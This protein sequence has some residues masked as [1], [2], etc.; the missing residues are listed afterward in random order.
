MEKKLEKCGLMTAETKIIIG[1]CFIVPNHLA[2]AKEL[3]PFELLGKKDLAFKKMMAKEVHSK[4]QVP[5]DNVYVQVWCC[6]PGDRSKDSTWVDGYEMAPS[7]YW[8]LDLYND[9][10]DKDL[11]E[12]FPKYLPLCLLKDLKDGDKIYIST[13]WGLVE[14]TMNQSGGDGRYG[15]FGKFEEVLQMLQKNF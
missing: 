5:T 15:K 2:D 10:K 14:L 11:G 8:D 7:K 13:K 1:E 4:I 9:L 6:T 12:N 3:F